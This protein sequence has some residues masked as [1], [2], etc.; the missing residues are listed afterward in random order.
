MSLCVGIDVSKEKCDACCIGEGGEKIFFVSCPMD[1]HGFDKLVVQL[2][3]DKTSFLLGMESTACYHIA[4]FS[5]LAAQGYQVV[6]INPLLIANFAK[7]SLRKTKTDKKAALTIAQFLMQEKKALCA[8]TPSHL[9]GE[10]RDLARRREKL[11]DQVTALKSDMKRILSVTFPELERLTG[12]FTKSTLRLLAEFPSAHALR[13]ASYAAIAAIVIPRSR[14]RKSQASV[15]ALMAAAAA[16]VGVTSPA[17]ELALKQEAALLLTVEE[18]IREAT[19]LLKSLCNERIKEDTEILCSMRGIGENTAVN[20]LVEMGGD[21]G[22]YES[23]KKLIAAAGLDP[24]TYQSGKYEGKSKISKR[25]NRHLRRVIW[26]MTTRVITNNDV[27]RAY[28]FKRRREGLPYKKAVLATAHKLIRVMYS[29]LVNQTYF[30][31]E[32][33]K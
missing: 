33:R 2:P 32:R 26:L 15:D 4:L 6:I 19:A 1:R 10:L 21:I 24:S 8:E 22:I 14:G 28:F 9:V 18:Q 3:A 29:M 31:P 17:K 11:T 7:R 5:Y 12:V 23:D 30:E 16:S 27:F 20:F 25:G 13:Q